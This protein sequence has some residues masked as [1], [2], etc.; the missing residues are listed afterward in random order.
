MGSAWENVKKGDTFPCLPFCFFVASPEGQ[1][2]SDLEVYA[3]SCVVEGTFCAP[4]CAACV[5]A[6]TTNSAI[7]V[8]LVDS[9]VLVERIVRTNYESVVAVPSVGCLK[10]YDTFAAKAVVSIEAAVNC[11]TETVVA[12]RCSVTTET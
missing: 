2:L 12:A 3:N 8:V 1:G 6:A 10:V 5:L 9:R 11:V 7:E 4:R